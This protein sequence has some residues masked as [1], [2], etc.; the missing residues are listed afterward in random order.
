MRF[1]LSL[2]ILGKLFFTNPLNALTINEDTIRAEYARFQKQSLHQISQNLGQSIDFV[3]SLSPAVRFV[4]SLH[5]TVNTTG[6]TNIQ[7]INAQ[8]IAMIIGRGAGVGGVSERQANAA[9]RAVL[10]KALRKANHKG[11]SEKDFNLTALNQNTTL[12]KHQLFVSNYLQGIKKSSPPQRLKFDNGLADNALIAHFGDIK[13]TQQYN[14]N[15]PTAPV[16]H[17]YNLDDENWDKQSQ[18]IN[19]R[20]TLFFPIRAKLSFND[21]FSTL[22]TEI[23][24]LVQGHQNV[25]LFFVVQNNPWPQN[26]ALLYRPHYWAYP[27]APAYGSYSVGFGATITFIPTPFGS[28]INGKK[29]PF[30]DGGFSVHPGDGQRIVSSGANCPIEDLISGKKQQ[31]LAFWSLIECN[32]RY[33][34]TLHWLLNQKDEEILENINGNWAPTNTLEKLG[35]QIAKN[36]AFTNLYT[37]AF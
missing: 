21:Y 32:G 8:M 10:L 34:L 11:A 20:N 26:Q 29:G 37:F 14:A 30:Y 36:R 1:L 31:S 2:V 27:D 17:P 25:D 9:E 16:I 6:D 18:A 28:T 33:A 22:P 5:H 3:Q 12:G 4:Y 24:S 23:A 35:N 15:L 13:I 7:K 19:Y